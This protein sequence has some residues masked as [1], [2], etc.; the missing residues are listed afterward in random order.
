MSLIPNVF[1]TQ[2]ELERHVIDTIT[3]CHDFYESPNFRDI[4]WIDVDT[5]YLLTYKELAFCTHFDTNTYLQNTVIADKLEPK[6]QVKEYT[7][8]VK[9]L[10]KKHTLNITHDNPVKHHGLNYYSLDDDIINI[11]PL[12]KFRNTTVFNAVALHEIAHATMHP[13]LLNRAPS[14]GCFVLLGTWRRIEEA[15]AELSSL[16][17]R[18]HYLKQ[19]SAILHINSIKYIANFIGLL[20]H[21]S[22]TEVITKRVTDVV[23]LLTE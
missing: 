10:V 19:E 9:F 1:M 2:E 16:I 20:K 6:E 22:L 13:R 11:A 17:I 14:R 18:E 4:K 8:I 7:S 12:E 15:I 21:P 3:E 5:L 23:N